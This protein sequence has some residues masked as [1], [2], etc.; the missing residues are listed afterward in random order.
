MI[1]FGVWTGTNI[2]H[3]SV[4]VVMCSHMMFGSAWSI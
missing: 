4:C 1:D 3:R 2:D